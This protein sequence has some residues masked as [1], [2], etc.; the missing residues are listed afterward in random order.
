MPQRRRR[1]AAQPPPTS[2]R[3][4][5]CGNASGETCCCAWLSNRKGATMPTDPGALCRRL[6]PADRHE[7]GKVMASAIAQGATSPEQIVN[8]V[9]VVLALREGREGRRVRDALR[10]QQAR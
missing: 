7:L 4:A 2:P 1:P 9:E 3:A 6:S 8:R 5:R 10:A